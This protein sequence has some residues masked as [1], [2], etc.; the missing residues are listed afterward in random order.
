[1]EN[2]FAWSNNNKNHLSVGA[3]ILNEENK[4]LVHKLERIGN[5]YFLPK[6]T[7]SNNKTLEETLNRVEEETGYKV[8]PTK[9][10]GSLQS[11]FPIEGSELVNKT[12]LYFLCQIQEQTQRNSND[13]DADSVLIWMDINELIVIMQ[14]QGEFENDLDESKILNNLVL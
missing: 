6:K 3:V 5:K 4:I 10:I 13:R 1:M 2:L 12:T 7:H 8:I 14:Q 9:Y 11:T